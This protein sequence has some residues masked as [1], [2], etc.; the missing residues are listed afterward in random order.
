MVQIWSVVGWMAVLLPTVTQ[1]QGVQQ[2]F[3][4]AMN[5]RAGPC[6]DD[7]LQIGYKHILDINVDQEKELQSIANGNA[8][9]TP[10]V[11]P[12]CNRFKYLMADTVLQVLLKDVVF[13][14]GYNGT[15][16]ELCVLEGHS[17]QVNVPEGSTTTNATFQGVSFYEFSGV[18]TKAY[19]AESSL[20]TFNDCRWQGYS[21]YATAIHQFNPAGGKPMKVV[22]NTGVFE[23]G[24]GLHLIDNVGGI[25]EAKNISVFEGV[26]ADSVIRTSQAGTSSLDMA[27]ATLADLVV[28]S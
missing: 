13:V 28:S 6:P 2:Y 1:A 5:E 16:Q 24:L 21:D 18:S 27:S 25:L 22:V 19:G 12:L 23:N 26:I 3:T 15:N 10:Y 4:N 9:R 8:P 20:I 7:P 17:E 14:C 11:F